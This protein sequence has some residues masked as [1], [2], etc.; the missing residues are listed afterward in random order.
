MISS[1]SITTLSSWQKAQAALLYHFASL[2]Y[3]KELHRMVSNLMDGVVDPLL[4]LSKS[5]N[6]DSALKDP[7]WGTRNTTENWSNNAWPFLRDF[8][9]SLAKDIAARAFERYE[10]TDANNCFRGI[11]EYSMLWATVEEE[12]RFNDLVKKISDYAINIDQTLDDYHHSRWSDY[13]FAYSYSE[14]AAENPKLPKFR[15][16]RD[17]IGESG[18]KPTRTG[19]Y[20]AQEDPYAALQFAWTGGP[21]GKLRPAKTLNDIGLA[22]LKE[23]GRKDLW[24]DDEKMFD[25][26]MRSPQVALF[27]PTIYMRGTEHRDF[28][29]GAVA[30]EA[31]SDQPRKWYFVEM[32]NGEFKDIFD[33]EDLSPAQWLKNAS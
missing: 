30:G 23:V 2:D 19:V 8:Q 32:I 26:A 27:K 28:A 29:A 1:T 18:K 22:A 10:I 4:T 21:G 13:G 9:V 5:Q 15:V 12:E 17:L 7:R 14:F 3:L 24:L 25:F 11:S 33:E 31:F 20:V 16:R 6:R